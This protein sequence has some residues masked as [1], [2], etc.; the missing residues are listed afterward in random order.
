MVYK[1]K[2]F[3]IALL[4]VLLLPVYCLGQD[5]ALDFDAEQIWD[6]QTDFQLP[7]ASDPLKLKSPILNQK[8]NDL[9]LNEINLFPTLP[10]LT[11]NSNQ[12]EQSSND[13]VKTSLA[14]QLNT[15]NELRKLTEIYSNSIESTL[16]E[17]LNSATQWKERSIQSQQYADMISQKLNEVV[18][19][20]K[21]IEAALISNNEDE[22]NTNLLFGEAFTRAEEAEAKVLRLERKTKNAVIGFSICGTGIG[23]GTGIAVHGICNDNL[24]NTLTGIGIDLASVSIWLLGH[25]V[26]EI[27]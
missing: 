11:T 24:Q 26:F 22:H 7:K 18:E 27:F 5:T 13:I 17:S 23:V 1:L 16:K 10:P 9:Q 21:R 14:N 4:L 3:L 8:T 20:N 15:V 6:L 19:E 25:Y 2:K 12:S